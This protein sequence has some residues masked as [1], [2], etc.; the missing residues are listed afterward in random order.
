MLERDTA[1]IIKFVL[2]QAGNPSPYYWKIPRSFMVPS[3]YFPTPEIITGT[4]TLTTYSMEYVFGIMFFHKTS[5]KA[6]WLALQ[7]LTAIRARRNMLAVVDTSGN[8]TKEILR[9]DDPK[10]KMPDN[11]AAQLEITWTSRRPYGTETATKTQTYHIG[12][13]DKPQLYESRVIDAAMEAALEKYI[14]R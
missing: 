7:V 5:E 9:V 2:D 12:Q 6:Y 14:Q 4:D 3:V 13:W 1:S 10:L 8:E 11:G